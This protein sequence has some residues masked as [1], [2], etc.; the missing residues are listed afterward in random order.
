MK[1]K[2]KLICS[3]HLLLLL[4]LAASSFRAY[5]QQEK[6]LS[7]QDAISLGLKHSQQIKNDSLNLK[8]ANS[9]LKQSKTNNLP[10][11]SIAA[12]FLRL[13]DNITPFTVSLPTGNVVLNPQILNQS[14]NAVQARQM[15][16]AG[17]K[18]RNADKI[19]ALEEQAITFDIQK[20]KSDLSYQMITLWY[21]LYSS[22]QTK[23]LLQSNIILLQNQ[24]MDA[25]NFVNQGIL[26]ENEVLKID[27]AISTLESSLA[28]IDNGILFLKNNLRI[29]T[30]LDQNV[31]VD[32]S[33]FLPENARNN[34]NLST[35]IAA[36]IRNRAELKVL[37]IRQ[38]QATLG[39][40]IAKSNYLPTLTGIGSFNYDQ[41][42]M[43]V[44]P[45]E[46]TFTGTYFAGL[47]LNW[48][49]TDLFT[50]K[51]KVAESKFG[52]QKLENAIEQ[53]KEGI[54]I[55]VN[56][57]Y[58]NYQSALQKI[59]IANKSIAQATENFRVEQNKFKANNASSTDFLNANTQLLNAR[60]AFATAQAAADL[61]YQ[62]LLKSIN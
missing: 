7:L 18:L 52:E 60:I 47:S 17:G 44:F 61:A 36:A 30:G 20:S 25:N 4:L 15:I 55:E 14:Y 49:I 21:N 28:D 29:L 56:A 54:E 3:K 45:N 40:K 62:K 32:I 59:A 38:Q 26:L 58:N 31:L 27:L 6:I 57:D 13:S 37:S 50:N 10:Q 34:E 23:K 11:V 12:N 35:L 43:R 41:P 8:I 19:A 39:S 46:A 1:M 5:C 51:N 2:Q 42:N 24:K 16:F 48:N 22:K 53:A 33:E 9:K